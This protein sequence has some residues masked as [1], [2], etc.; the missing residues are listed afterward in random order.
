MHRADF[1]ATPLAYL[2]G[3]DLKGWH[4]SG[5]WPVFEHHEWSLVGAFGRY[6]GTDDPDPQT[7]E[8]PKLT[9]LSYLAG[10]RYTFHTGRALPFVQVT[11]GGVDIATSHP[12]AAGAG[13]R[14]DFRTHAF[15]A[16]G[17]GIHTDSGWHGLRLRVQLEYVYL[18]KD[19]KGW[20]ISVGPTFV[21]ATVPP[22]PSP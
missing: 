13:D 16:V 8:K 2:K 1:Y 12:G 4:F 15:A 20:L 3:S 22:K 5:S 6:T 17:G 11:A 21:F 7:G 10:A 9:L 14:V 19:H 18:P